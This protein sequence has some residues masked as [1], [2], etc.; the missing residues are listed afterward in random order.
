MTSI[1]DTTF[2]R[3]LK[4]ALYWQL[5]L[6]LR[7]SILAGRLKKGTKLPSTRAL[8][9]ELNV[10][11]NTV[12]NAYEQLLAEGYLESIEASGT[13]VAA[14]LPDTF[15][16]SAPSP[17]RPGR[18]S[19]LDSPHPN[20][21]R[22]GEVISAVPDLAPHTGDEFRQR[23]F[24]AGIPALDAFPSELWGKLVARRARH[25]TSQA[26]TYQES[27]GYQ[28]LREVIAAHVTVTRRVHCTPDQV[29]ITAGSQ[30]ALD[31]AARV[32]LSPGDSVWI[33]DPGYPGARGALL[34]A[35]A[36]IIP[37]PVD[38]EGLNVSAGIALCPDARLVYLTPSHQFPLGM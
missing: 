38:N 11:R 27:I 6:H 25:I 18:S 12:L 21:S 16:T 5:Y 3:S 30:G 31:L 15:M 9:A 13:F 4:T 19:Q 23:P 33:E 2:D 7:D 34:A 17:P 35:G 24:V 32:L 1:A 14:A 29:I 37:V 28:P 20:L 36:T 10:S 26:L 8:A 22:N